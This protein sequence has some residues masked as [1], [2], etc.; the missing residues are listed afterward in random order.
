MN[1][2]PTGTAANLLPDG[3]TVHSTLTPLSKT[4][5]NKTAQ[6]LITHCFTNIR[7]NLRVIGWKEGNKH[8][9]FCL[10][11]DEWSMFSHRLLG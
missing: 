11:M 9:L 10:N 2:A 1:I 6:M 7:K 3:R 8:Q 5:D 4:K